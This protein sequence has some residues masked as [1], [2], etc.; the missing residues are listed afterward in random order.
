MHTL[1]ISDL[2]LSP[3]RPDIT[4]CFTHF[5]RTEARDADALYV[6]G[7]LFDFWIGDD[8]PTPFAQ[9]I[10]AEFQQL[11]AAGVACFFVHGNRD[12]L[13]GQRFAKET[14]I[15]LLAQETVIH[16]YGTPVVILHGDTLCTEDV[17]YLAFREKVHKPW[18]QWV[19]NRLPYAIKKRIVQRV[20]SDIRHDKQQKAMEIMD[21]TPSEVIQV[22]NHHHVDIMIHG[23]T[24]RPAIHHLPQLGH[25][26]RI[27]LGD[28][29]SQGSILRY[30]PQG[31]A[32]ESR[33]FE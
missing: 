23:H 6:L 8:D 27:V 7:D 26:T 2:H 25:K 13:I 22:L 33:P 24:H 31:Y 32:L 10:K 19:F 15:V 17:R 3:A 5:M 4:Q 14:G 9:Q 29:Y 20:Q 12:F 18:L 11:T 30:A 21:V 16:L 1:F 28:W